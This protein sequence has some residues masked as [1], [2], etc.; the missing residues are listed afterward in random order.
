M[1]APNMPRANQMAAK[2]DMMM[3]PLTMV[4]SFV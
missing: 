2:K 3:A 4:V 1:P